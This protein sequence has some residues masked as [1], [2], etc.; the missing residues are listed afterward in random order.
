MGISQRITSNKSRPLW[1]DPVLQGTAHWI[2]YKKQYYSGHL[3]NEGAIVSEVTSLLNSFMNSNQRVRCEVQYS[4]ISKKING[5]DRAD[6]VGYTDEK[7]DFVIEVKRFEAG[8]KLID[9]DLLKLSKI[10]E[11][12]KEIRCLLLMVSQSKAPFPFI[13]DKGVADRLK[14]PISGTNLK[15]QTIRVCKSVSSFGENAYLKADYACII[16]VVVS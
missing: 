12:N 8:K 11:V 2:G 10:K 6:I 9:S 13:N 14:I 3:I 1:I 4:D 7:I 5:S 15:F 16:E